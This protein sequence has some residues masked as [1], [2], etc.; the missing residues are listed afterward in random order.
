MPS[1]PMSKGGFQIFPLEK[2]GYRL[3]GVTATALY[4][5][6]SRSVFAARRGEEW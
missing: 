4:A 2:Q 1:R 3:V 6:V 5:L